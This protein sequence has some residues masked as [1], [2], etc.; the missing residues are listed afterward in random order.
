MWI[1]AAHTDQYGGPG[2]AGLITTVSVQAV[3]GRKEEIQILQLSQDFVSID[4][5]LNWLNSS[6][7]EISFKQP[8]SVEFQVIKCAGIDISIRENSIGN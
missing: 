7:L 4:L 1:A 6:H 8:V 3:Y 2:T 5:K